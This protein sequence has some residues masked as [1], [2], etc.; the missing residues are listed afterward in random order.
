MNFWKNIYLRKIK[1]VANKAVYKPLLGL[2][3]PDPEASGLGNFQAKF[4]TFNGSCVRYATAHTQKTLG[5]IP[6]IAEKK[7]ISLS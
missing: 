7:L 6:L 5:V 1:P 3:N 4:C 2:A